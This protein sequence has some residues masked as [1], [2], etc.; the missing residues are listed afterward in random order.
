MKIDIH[1]KFMYNILTCIS[2]K[3]EN[4]SRDSGATA[5]ITKKNKD[6]L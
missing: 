3:V 1:I 2:K 5:V 6:Y 4:D